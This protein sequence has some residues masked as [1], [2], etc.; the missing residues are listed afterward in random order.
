[1]T[2]FLLAVVLLGPTSCAKTPVTSPEPGLAHHSLGE[3]PMRR[4]E[5]VG[6]VEGPSVEQPGTAGSPEAVDCSTVEDCAGLLRTE[7]DRTRLA[8]AGTRLAG[9]GSPEAIEALGGFLH[10]PRFLARLD[11][12]DSLG[13]KTRHLSR[14][15]RV[16][17]TV[18]SPAV[19]DLCL[20]LARNPSFLADPDRLIFLLETVAAV[21]PMTEQT[22]AL[23]VATNPQG[24]APSNAIL[25]GRNAS[26][27]ALGLFETMLLSETFEP[28][29]RVETIRSA[30]LPVRN[31]KSV[32]ELA[33]H[34]LSNSLPIEVEIALVE[35]LFDY[36]PAQWFGKVG[37]PPQPPPWT[38]AT[39]PALRH[40]L[41]LGRALRRRKRLPAAL[42][43]R[44]ARTSEEI[45]AVLEP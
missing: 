42:R 13:D 7:T 23:F 15:L 6:G 43:Q 37:N 4:V 1:M 22:V 2:R 9:L 38:S 39:K 28:E 25:L 26:P 41:T 11:Q 24:H 18:P 17:Q 27:N 44:I 3:P 16:L 30:L 14:I 35:T 21:R 31:H 5:E 12:V 40:V 34:M 45:R 36:R 10:D 33:D 8:A 19:A 32:V 20:A 29:E